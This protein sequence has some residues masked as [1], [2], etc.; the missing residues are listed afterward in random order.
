MLS[1]AIKSNQF[2]LNHSFPNCQRTQIQASTQQQLVEPWQTE[3]E[4]KWMIKVKWM[5]KKQKNNNLKGLFNVVCDR[6]QP[7]VVGCTLKIVDFEKKKNLKTKPLFRRCYKILLVNQ[8]HLTVKLFN[9]V[10]INC[11]T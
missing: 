1:S 7:T 9:D 5:K 10:V 4:Q 6:L 8:K 2:G 11:E 3:E